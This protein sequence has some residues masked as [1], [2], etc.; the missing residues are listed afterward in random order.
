MGGTDDSSSALQVARGPRSP[1]GLRAGSRDPP[2]VTVRTRGVLVRILAGSVVAVVLAGCP[3]PEL[4][5]P[6]SAQAATACRDAMRVELDDPSV[7]LP[8]PNEP[9]IDGDLVIGTYL[10]DGVEVTT[11]CRFTFDRETQ[12]Y[13]ALDTGLPGH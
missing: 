4:T 13:E 11:E 12:G 10:V 6:N 7:E 5:D 8:D 9:R 2:S 3:E 1:G